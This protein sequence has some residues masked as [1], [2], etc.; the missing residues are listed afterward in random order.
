MNSRSSRQLSNGELLSE[1]RRGI[2]RPSS[3][4]HQFSDELARVLPGSAGI[5]RTKQLQEIATVYENDPVLGLRHWCE[6]VP[7]KEFSKSLNLDDWIILLLT[8][9]LHY[10]QVTGRKHV[11]FVGWPREC[12]NGMFRELGRRTSREKKCI[13]LWNKFVDQLTKESLP[14]VADDLNNLILERYLAS[15]GDEAEDFKNMGVFV[16]ENRNPWKKK[17]IFPISLIRGLNRS[18]LEALLA[19]KRP[20]IK[21]I[22]LQA[23]RQDMNDQINEYNKIF[24]KYQDVQ[25][26]LSM[27]ILMLQD[28]KLA[29]RIDDLYKPIVPS[30]ASLLARLTELE[31]KRRSKKRRPN[32]KPLKLKK[33]LT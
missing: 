19:D 10:S 27:L 4:H 12:L 18:H 14:K 31:R 23:M 11:K 9:V 20:D 6:S 5:A 8:L 13:N 15:N 32:T 3:V 2:T 17:Y 26:Y 16:R 22:A 24:I 25:G 1:R 7:K 28:K 30:H 29:H 33:V 21:Q